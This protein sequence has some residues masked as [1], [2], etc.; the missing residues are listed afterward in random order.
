MG[1]N[2]F[3]PLTRH[4]EHDRQRKIAC[5]PW[6][7]VQVGVAGWSLA[8]VNQMPRRMEWGQ[9][10]LKKQRGGHRGGSSQRTGLHSDCDM[11][12]TG[13]LEL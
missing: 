9:T 3:V 5:S 8:F 10:T 11:A 4:L 12:G 1:E 6:A 2:V 13:H 7:G